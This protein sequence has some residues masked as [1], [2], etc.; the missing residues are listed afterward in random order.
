L[1]PSDEP[2]DLDWGLFEQEAT[3]VET[4]DRIEPPDDDGDVIVSDD[5]LQEEIEAA[6]L[7]EGARLARFMTSDDVD[8]YVIQ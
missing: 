5:L 1:E 6:H 2:N 8:G 3:G 4:G 7:L